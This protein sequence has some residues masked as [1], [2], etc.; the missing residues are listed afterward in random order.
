MYLKKRFFIIDNLKQK[1]TKMLNFFNNISFTFA[2]FQ[3]YLNLLSIWTNKENSMHWLSNMKVRI[4]LWT[5]RNDIILNNL[6]L[7]SLMTN[8]ESNPDQV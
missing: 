8:N 7:L 4:V 3:L 5:V 2:I 6:N 1:E